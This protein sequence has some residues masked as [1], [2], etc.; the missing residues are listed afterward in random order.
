MQQD[1]PADGTMPKQVAGTASPKARM[2]TSALPRR[3]A[4]DGPSQQGCMHLQTA[5]QERNISHLS[6]PSA[7]QA[8]AW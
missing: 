6:G 8:R 7:P 2:T 4:S 1:N 3:A 5:L